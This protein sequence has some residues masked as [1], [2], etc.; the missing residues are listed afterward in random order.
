MSVNRKGVVVHEKCCHK[1]YPVR[2]ISFQVQ[3]ECAV[4]L[5]WLREKFFSK[6]FLLVIQCHHLGQ[7][8]L[9]LTFCNSVVP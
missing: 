9:I 4:S 1:S 5:C 3:D 7:N 2:K 6:E 8:E